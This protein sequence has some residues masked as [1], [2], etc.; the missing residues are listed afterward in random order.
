LSLFNEL[1]RRNVFRVGVAYIIVAWLLMQV[2]ETLSPALRLPEWTNSTLAFFLILGFPVAMFFAWAFELTPD[3]IKKEGEVDNAESITPV[4]GRKLDYFIIGLLAV[5]LAYFVWE[6]RFREDSSPATEAGIQAKQTS[7]ADADVTELADD[8]EQEASKLSIAVLPFENRSSREEDQFFT[9]GIHDDLLTTIAKIGSMKVISRTSVMEYKE[10]VKKIP[11]IAKELGVANILEGGIQR[12]GNQVRINVQLIDAETDEHLW[13]EI[14]DRE[15]T[16]ENLFAIQSEI[17]KAIANALQAALTPQEEQR[18]DSRPTENLLAFNAYLRGRQL[19]ATRDGEKLKLAIEEFNR[20]V[21]LDPEFALAWVGVADSNRLYPAYSNQNREDF[22]P[23]RQHAVDRALSIDDQLGEAYASLGSL[24]ADKEQFEL[25]ESAFRQAIAL[26]PNY[27]T[28]WQWYSHII[29]SDPLRNAEGIKLLNRAAELDPRSSIIGLNLAGEYRRAGLYLLAEEQYRKIIERAPAFMLAQVQL[30]M[31]YVYEMG[32]YD[33]AWEQSRKM[34]E[35]SPDN[36]RALNIQITIML[37]IGNISAA[38]IIHEQM[39][40]IDPEDIRVFTADININLH[41][42]DDTA[43]RAAMDLFS[44]KYADS[45]QIAGSTTYTEL[46]LGNSDRARE[47]YLSVN[48]EWGDPDTWPINRQLLRSGCTSA[49]V[50]INTGDEKAG[51]ELLRKGTQAFEET[52]ATTTEHL[53]YLRPEICY[54]TAGNTEKA[55]R[56]LEEQVAHNHI[57]D[58]NVDHLA[59]MY[60]LIRDEPRYQAVLQERERK[61]A[62]Q[63]EV[64]AR[65]ELGSE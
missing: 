35:I 52:F 14:Y 7:G 39:K 27:A 2:G 25:A 46:T 22:F 50:L 62:V 6:S 24:H 32:R 10:T 11:Q 57:T 40:T 53:D 3:G 59:P 42:S 38:E 51:Q 54:L 58:W 26:S 21:E 8:S 19:M 9:D 15:L 18:I 36:P 61:I 65:M 33:L 1:K 47:K 23:A 49:W 20:A 64:I 29:L 63:R 34:L 55:L 31:L 12:S 56:S 37:Q 16:A 13:A 28:G 60:D 48:P 45:P 41:K 4:T 17:S 30:A 43:V 5:A 44:V